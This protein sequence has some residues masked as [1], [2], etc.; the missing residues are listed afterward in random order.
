MSTW[1]VD[2]SKLAKFALELRSR[3]R[4]KSKR[5][6]YEYTRLF[7]W[8]IR[9]VAELL[10]NTILFQYV[11]CHSSL[12]KY[13][14]SAIHSVKTGNS[15]LNLQYR[16]RRI[17]R[18]ARIYV[19]CEFADCVTKSSLD[20]SSMTKVVKRLNTFDFLYYHQSAK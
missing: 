3:Y 18:I 11:I 12:R 8:M 10:C 14:K 15:E 20:T 16:V 17:F 6:A 2:H 19:V 1:R 4:L 9:G 13:E 7:V 5:F